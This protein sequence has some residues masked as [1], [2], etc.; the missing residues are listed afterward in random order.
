MIGD[1]DACSGADVFCVLDGGVLVGL[2]T[3]TG[4]TACDAVEEARVGADAFD[5]DL[6]AASNA[7]A[8]SVLIHAALLFIHNPAVSTQI[9]GDYEHL[10]HSSKSVG[11][12]GTYSA[13][14]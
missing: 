3:G 13:R 12:G 2:R 14:G 5:V 9:T 10:W 1:G 8:S 11:P 6:T 7:T 4:E